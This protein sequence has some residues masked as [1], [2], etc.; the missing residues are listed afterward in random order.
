MY[1]NEPTLTLALAVSLDESN[2]D[3]AV[4]TKSVRSYTIPPTQRHRDGL[5]AHAGGP[6]SRRVVPLL[7]WRMELVESRTA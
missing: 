4:A 7:L 1:A 3:N 2:H 5:T 6:L